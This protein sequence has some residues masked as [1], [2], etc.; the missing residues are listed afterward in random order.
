MQVST[1]MRYHPTAVRITII[2]KSENYKCSQ[3]RGEKGTLVLCWWE[4]KLLQSICKTV[5]G[6][7]Q[8][9]KNRTII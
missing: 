6:F 3:R 4:C 2:E 7:P 1:T 8:K 9:T 5:G